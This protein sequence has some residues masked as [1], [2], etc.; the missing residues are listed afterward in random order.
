MELDKTIQKENDKALRI[1]VVMW[2]F[3][4]IT[5]FNIK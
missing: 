4:R 3:Y 1:A 5:N 2:R